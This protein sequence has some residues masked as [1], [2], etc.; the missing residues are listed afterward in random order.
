[1]EVYYSVSAVIF[2]FSYCREPIA[3]KGFNIVI[4]IN[5]QDK[6]D[7]DKKSDKDKK[8]NDDKKEDKKDEKKE[9]KKDDRNS[10]EEE[11]G[12]GD[13]CIFLYSRSYI[14]AFLKLDIYLFYFQSFVFHHLLA[15]VSV[16]T[17]VAHLV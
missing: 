16:H 9:D 7:K 5:L 3:C 15:V 1:M 4:G 12:S 11:D 13:V 17:L 14:F 10:I 2:Q 8:D 6:K